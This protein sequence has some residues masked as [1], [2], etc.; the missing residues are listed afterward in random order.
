MAK[1]ARRQKPKGWRAFDDLTRR[2]VRVPKSEVDR[3]EAERQKLERTRALT[4]LGAASRQE[5]EEVTATHEARATELAAARQRLVLLG[6][7]ADH[8]GRLADA[9]HIVSE[10]TVV[11]PSDGVV[12]ARSVNPGQVIGA[13]QDL[14]TVT[15]LGTVWVIGALAFILVGL[16][17]VL[18]FNLWADHRPLSFVPGFE[19]ANWF[20]A[21]DGITSRILLPL[22]GLVTAIFIGWIADRRLVDPESGLSPGGLLPVWR[23]LVAWLCPVAVALILVFSLFPWLIGS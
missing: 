5:L 17:S 7:G 8:V 9:S 23:F 6:L 21:F 18:S 14:F 12:I 2:L 13:G 4:R 15:D 1:K 3:L 11:A 19:N 22:S 10:V 16:T 20:D